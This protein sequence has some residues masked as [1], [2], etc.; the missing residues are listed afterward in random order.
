MAKEEI[1]IFTEALQF[2]PERTKKVLAAKPLPR[3]REELQNRLGECDEG[4]KNHS[5]TSK[6]WSILDRILAPFEV[7]GKILNAVMAATPFAPASLILGSC[8]HL[9]ETA[10]KFSASYQSI[11]EFLN[12]IAGT[13]DR[14]AIHQEA[15]ID[16]P[17]RRILVQAIAL[18]SEVLVEASEQLGK[19][20]KYKWSKE[21]LTRLFFGDSSKIE[22]KMASLHELAE[23]EAMMCLS[24]IRRDTTMFR[25][26][27]KQ[28]STAVRRIEHRGDQGRFEEIFDLDTWN[29][30]HN[31]HDEIVKERQAGVNAMWITREDI[32]A[33]WM[34]GKGPKMIWIHGEPAMGKTFLASRLISEHIRR[35]GLVA[36]FY[37]R[38]SDTSGNLAT[39]I[40]KCLALQLSKKSQ[41]FQKAAAKALENPEWIRNEKEI[42]SK[43]F[44]PFLKENTT[45]RVFIVID[46]LDAVSAEEQKKVVAPWMDLR[47][48]SSSKWQINIA[49]VSRF[50]V[51]R[52][53][54]D[55][56]PAGAQLRV[57]S[58]RVKSD[59]DQYIER[60]FNRNFPLLQP[61]DRALAIG[62]LQK[63]ANGVF[64]WVRLV[65]EHIEGWESGQE[66]LHFLEH[67]YPKNKAD[68][69]GSI[70]AGAMKK[71]H[72]ESQFKDIL[73]W[74]ACSRRPLT[75]NELQFLHTTKTSHGRLEVVAGGPGD[76]EKRFKQLLTFK[77][78]RCFS[79]SPSRVVNFKH[80]CFK[81][82]LLYG[83]GRG[84]HRFTASEAHSSILKT[85]LLCLH[86]TNDNVDTR[87]GALDMIS[88]AASHVI[89]HFM[90]IEEDGLGYQAKSQLLELI[91]QPA[92]IAR[93]YS[94]MDKKQRL[95]LIST[96]LEVPRTSRKL[97]EWLPGSYESLQDFYQPF[98]FSCAES[99]L[100][101]GSMDTEFC[102]L[103]LDRYNKLGEKQLG[104]T[105]PSDIHI[106][107]ICDLRKK[108][109][110][111]LAQ[112][113]NFKKDANWHVRVASAL[114]EANHLKAAIDMY[115]KAE[116]GEYDQWVIK[117]GIAMAYA[118]Q[119]HYEKAVDQVKISLLC[120]PRPDNVSESNIYLNL[121]IWHGKCGERMAQTDA[122]QKAYDLDSGSFQKLAHL[123]CVLGRRSKFGRL[124]KLCKSLSS[125]ETQSADEDR[126]VH[127]LLGWEEG[128]A[129]FSRAAVDGRDNKNIQF[130]EHIFK[131][132]IDVARN[133][134]DTEGAVFEEY[135]RGN[136]YWQYVND[137][138]QAC[139]IWKNM[140]AESQED[141]DIQL[142]VEQLQCRALGELYL[143]MALSSESTPQAKQP[144]WISKLESLVVGSPG[145]PSAQEDTDYRADAAVM[146]GYW[147]RKHGGEN[148]SRELFRATICQG[149]RILEDQDPW[150]DKEGYIILGR[151]LVR[152][153]YPDEGRRAFATAVMSPIR[154][155]LSTVQR[156]KGETLNTYG[157]I[158][159]CCG[160]SGCKEKDWDKIY[161]CQ[162]C[163]EV[164]L[165]GRCLKKLRHD[166]LQFTCDKAHIVSPVYDKDTSLAK[167]ITD[168]PEWLNK[169][170]KQWEIDDTTKAAIPL[171]TPRIV[172]NCQR[173]LQICP[174]G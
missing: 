83:P 158:L 37:V 62:T 168:L 44:L 30:M 81:D 112:F 50:E 91:R 74:V 165:C 60:K 2:L 162:V 15:R 92:T 65:I 116:E 34:E 144:D 3:N 64:L 140:G 136:F 155:N 66:I 123:F 33:R 164:A 173:R 166:K 170:K 87:P 80:R 63:E 104:M 97:M 139:N 101:T 17:L 39:T 106:P 115:H 154:P 100:Q 146:L 118:A 35:K 10:R 26:E 57:S 38:A 90:E 126:L 5:R 85:C 172:I 132:T 13:L 68:H 56:C 14:M 124:F 114:C 75:D 20:R 95:R 82:D 135:L 152:A 12:R 42:W 171:P 110:L 174:R 77:S 84:I 129:L 18:V 145:R 107:R 21:F 167:P 125:S 55:A 151:A 137:A 53:V 142:Y 71:D 119:G 113:G 93:W 102:V 156:A 19:G 54:Q 46:G 96:L 111:E 169:Q 61:N 67:G 76:V 134:G 1:D 128:H 70:L 163:Q 103:F 43:I 73:R 32:V 89:D 27:L 9:M 69:I 52:T 58:A 130:A 149:I 41:K 23:A 45:C 48:S 98:A 51:H 7:T 86:D 16:A 143:R 11:Q 148:T 147:K 105:S 94:A 78:S 36:Y 121:S 25:D 24:I 127:L 161:M 160:G 49:I 29:A 141:P 22:E 72:D 59:I 133:N 31:I 79:E 8:L 28:L 40:F 157:A 150:N 159:A 120:K 99:W 131:R 109:I 88:Y 117:S 108:R 6:F 122:A 4:F 153:G 47:R 138:G